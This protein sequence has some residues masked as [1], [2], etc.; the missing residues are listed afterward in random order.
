MTLLLVLNRGW[1]VSLLLC[2][3]GEKAVVKFPTAL[4]VVPVA[5]GGGGGSTIKALV[6][7]GGCRGT[8]VGVVHGGC[9]QHSRL[10]QPF[11]AM[12]S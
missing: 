8:Y 3:A 1:V 11:G 10:Y 4:A 6:D 7:R 9:G 12:L 5:H 2:F